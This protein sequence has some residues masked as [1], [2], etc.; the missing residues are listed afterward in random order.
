MKIG[1][2][3]NNLT[4]YNYT[5]HHDTVID[6]HLYKSNILTAKKATSEHTS[7]FTETQLNLP[8]GI[9]Y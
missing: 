5:P 7:Y 9:S 6:Y 1:E 2:I 4:Q 8:I 3:K